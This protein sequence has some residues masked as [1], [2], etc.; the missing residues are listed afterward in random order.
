MTLTA[1]PALLEDIDL[2]AEIPCDGHQECPDQVGWLLIHQCCNHREH[3]CMRHAMTTNDVLKEPGALF[4][5]AGCW[6]SDLPGDMFRL[7]CL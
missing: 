7:V 1:D 5:C 4:T 3:L 2:E 6:S